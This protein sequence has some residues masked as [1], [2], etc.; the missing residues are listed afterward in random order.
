MLTKSSYQ[1]INGTIFSNT[2]VLRCLVFSSSDQVSLMKKIGYI[3]YIQSSL[4]NKSYTTYKVGKPI[5]V[6]SYEHQSIDSTNIKK[7][8]LFYG[9]LICKNHRD[10]P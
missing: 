10:Q 5:V 4:I 6:M 9:H 2:Q 1:S 7:F 3:F 8:T